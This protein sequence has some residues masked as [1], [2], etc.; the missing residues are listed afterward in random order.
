MLNRLL[1]KYRRYLTNYESALAYA[2]L[3]VVGGVAS[4]LVVIAFEASIR[5]L[6]LLWGVGDGGDA[7]EALPQW[8]LFALPA[9]GGVLLGLAFWRRWRLVVIFAAA[10]LLHL[11]FDFPL[12]THDARQ[13]FWR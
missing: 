9:G 3:G 1:G 13:H 11:T 5:Q 12:H 2:L 4:G 7:F 8:L 10:G 6:A